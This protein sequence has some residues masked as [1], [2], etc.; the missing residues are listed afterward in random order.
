ML[1][2][3]QKLLEKTSATVEA[4]PVSCGFAAGLIVAFVVLLLL[5]LLFLIL[6][7]R[8]L[9]CI[10]I[11]SEDGMLRID[12]RAVQDAVRA[13]AESF[14]AFSVR[15]VELRGTQLELRLAV[16]MDFLGDNVGGAS[17]SISTVAS[18]FRS[19]MG[20]MMTETFGMHKPARIDLEIV[21]SLAK[22]SPA[23]GSGSGSENGSGSGGKPEP[24]SESGSES[25]SSFGTESGSG[26]GSGSGF[27]TESG[28]GSSSDGA[29]PKTA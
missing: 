20:R 23:E 8:K 5:F 17:V 1:Q 24:G 4:H 7:S 15:K 19:A 16:A 9:R 2:S 3:I 13:V 11:N 10:E 6:R 14:P 18:G 26:S 25:G 27:G 12:S 21:R 29:E 28:S 22:Y